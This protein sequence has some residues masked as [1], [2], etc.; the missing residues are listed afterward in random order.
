M[1]IEE[2]TPQMRPGFVAMDR[3]K[4]W[5]YFEHSPPCISSWTGVWKST[6]SASQPINL[7]ILFNI[8]PADDWKQS[9][10]VSG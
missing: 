2:L 5:H 10:L 9:L 4:T 7:S 8:E 6:D 3:N 1:R